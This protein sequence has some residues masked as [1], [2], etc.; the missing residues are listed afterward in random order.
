MKKTTLGYVFIEF[1]IMGRIGILFSTWVQ[2]INMGFYIG[3][4]YFQTIHYY[5]FCLGIISFISVFLFWGYGIYSYIFLLF[6]IV[7]SAISWYVSWFMYARMRQI[8]IINTMRY[9]ASH[10]LLTIWSGGLALAFWYMYSAH[11]EAVLT[12]FLMINFFATFLGMIWYMLSKFRFMER[13]FEWQ[14]RKELK[15][16]RDM[17]M[18]FREEKKVRLVDDELLNGYEWGSDS[19]IDRLFIQAKRQHEAGE[20][21]FA[22]T[23]REIEI[24]L[25]D[26]RIRYLEN[27]IEEF[28]KKVA[29]SGTD[30]RLLNT[31]RNL[32]RSYR[33][34]IMDYNRLFYSK[35]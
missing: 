4:E 24:A 8:L 28:E 16:A 31:Y 12:S 35:F 14:D 3:P 21:L 10:V 5:F 33:K 32:I 13:I 27:K 18:A 25:C 20:R 29:L 26:L 17:M 30:R 6:Y 15:K 34:K 23:I 1:E 7:H 11:Y 22:E 9:A 19:K 2:L